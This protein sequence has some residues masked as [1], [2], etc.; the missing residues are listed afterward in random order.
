[1]FAINSH[2]DESLHLVALDPLDGKILGAH[3]TPGA[4][5]VPASDFATA[6]GLNCKFGEK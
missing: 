2:S 3:A 1:M 6:S 4:A 5:N